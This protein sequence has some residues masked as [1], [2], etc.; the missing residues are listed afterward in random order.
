MN[1]VI[2][3]G[4]SL[5]AGTIVCAVFGLI[6]LVVLFIT[7]AVRFT[8]RQIRSYGLTVTRERHQ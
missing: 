7:Q 3:Y 4:I 5:L 2:N 1:E 6:V 8:I